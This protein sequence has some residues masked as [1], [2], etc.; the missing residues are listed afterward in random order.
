MT[1]RPLLSLLLL[2]FLLAP[3]MAQTHHDPAELIADELVTELTTK[4]DAGSFDS[5]LSDIS[6]DTGLSIT[7]TELDIKKRYVPLQFLGDLDDRLQVSVMPGPEGDRSVLNRNACEEELTID[8][9]VELYIDGANSVGIAD[10]NR[11][12]R[13]IADIIFFEDEDADR[14]QRRVLTSVDARVRQERI[15][16]RYD[17]A[18]LLEHT[19]YLGFRRFILEAET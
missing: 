12:T 18:E 1:V 8:L 9:A 17:P 15:L 13:K 3:L 16:A 10:L 6:S 7:K 14:R 2:F 11:L 4:R 19:V 5:I